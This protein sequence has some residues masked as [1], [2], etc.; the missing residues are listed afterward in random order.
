[1]TFSSLHTLNVGTSFIPLD[2]VTLCIRQCTDTLTTLDIAGEYLSFEVVQ[3]VLRTIAGRPLRNLNIGVT[4]LSP[5]LVDLLAEHLPVLTKLSLRIRAVSA[6][7]HEPPMFIGASL[8]QKQSQV[9]RFRRDG[10]PRVWGVPGGRV[11]V[12]LQAAVLSSV[13]DILHD[14]LETEG[15]FP[16]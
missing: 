13:V 2:V 15:R 12:Y 6:D 9:E 8:M 11:K 7:R 1:M 5:Q 4:C 10:H 16:E 3:D 14:S